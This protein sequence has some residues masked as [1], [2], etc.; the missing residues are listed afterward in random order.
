[1]PSERKKHAHP[2]K[3]LST[4]VAP[5]ARNPDSATLQDELP[6]LNPEGNLNQRW[7]IRAAIPQGHYPKPKLRFQASFYRGLSSKPSGLGTLESHHRS[8]PAT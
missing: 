5:L 7:W 2:S 4:S 3:T 8:P 1:M 6:Q